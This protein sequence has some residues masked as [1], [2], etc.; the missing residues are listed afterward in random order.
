MKISDLFY[1]A[2]VIKSGFTYPETVGSKELKNLF[3]DIENNGEEAE[4]EIEKIYNPVPL[5]SEILKNSGLKNWGSYFWDDKAELRISNSYLEDETWVCEYGM[6]KLHL[7]YVHEL[8][9]FLKVC[10]IDMEIIV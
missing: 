9:Y 5:S 3:M 1:G 2:W 10:E 8:Q 7:R 4:K 6:N